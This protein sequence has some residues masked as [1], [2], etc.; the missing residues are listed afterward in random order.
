[1]IHDGTLPDSVWDRVRY[2]PSAVSR[3]ECGLLYAAARKSSGPMVEIGSWHGRTAIVLGLG[4][5]RSRRVWTVDPFDEVL[6]AGGSVARET[7]RMALHRNLG[8]LHLHGNV[9][10][11]IHATSEE[12]AALWA[13]E[14]PLDRVGLLFIDGDH[15]PEAVALD[16]RLWLPLLA[17]GALVALHDAT[18]DGPRAVIEDALRTGW[19]VWGL[20]A[21]GEGL[22]VLEAPRPGGLG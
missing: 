11:T 16:W 2:V 6:L 19:R 20:R 14:R 7:D 8:A 10:R 3:D 22:T 13:E 15:R 4:G 18:W 17:P 21:E 1:M 12:A 9:V 5:G